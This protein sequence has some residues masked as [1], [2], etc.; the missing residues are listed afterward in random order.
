M[1]LRDRE[2]TDQP[3]GVNLTILPTINPVPYD[4]H[5]AAIIESGVTILETAGWDP[6]PRSPLRSGATFAD[7]VHLA[8]LG[9]PGAWGAGDIEVEMW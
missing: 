4:E 8:C 2:L 6:S 5:G 1:I 3:F 7:V 9:C